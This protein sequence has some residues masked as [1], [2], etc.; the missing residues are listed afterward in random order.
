MIRSE[1][2]GLWIG[3]FFLL[4]HTEM[5][6]E[7]SPSFNIHSRAW[8]LR[9]LLHRTKSHARKVSRDKGVDTKF[10]PVQFLQSFSSKSLRVSVSIPWFDWRRTNFPTVCLI[11]IIQLRWQTR[12]WIKKHLY[13][14][15]IEA[16]WGRR[17]K[18]PHQNEG[19]GV[20]DVN[21]HSIHKTNPLKETVDT[22]G[23]RPTA[24]KQIRFITTTATT[25]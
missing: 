22:S 2:C 18:H 10:Q 13:P 7:N 25:Y 14:W 24:L 5:N 15:M 4:N 19:G 1:A 3:V 11:Y 23:R 20:W 16:D 12:M 8:N 9:I 17:K 21:R 6:P